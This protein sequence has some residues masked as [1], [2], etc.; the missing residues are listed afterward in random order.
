MVDTLK[1]YL[2]DTNHVAAVCRKDAAIIRKLDAFPA[3]TQIRTNVITLGE[4][5]AG[6][7]IT[8]TTNQKK[9]DEYV[10]ELEK[11]FLPE[12]LPI[13]VK[14]R[15]YYA[16]I[17]GRLWDKHGP[18]TRKVKTERWLVEQFAVDINDI[19]SV[20]IAWDHGFTFV[21]TDEM[22]RIK[23][24]ISDDEVLFDCWLPKRQN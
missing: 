13:T 12:V 11:R 17:M 21:T 20:A 6:N 2:L 1:G 3:G 8:V 4:V 22:E 7:R 14:T 10:A 23:E 16:E 19:W 15:F 5:E 24:V 9:R 18:P